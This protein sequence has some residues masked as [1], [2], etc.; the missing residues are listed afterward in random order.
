MLWSLMI[1]QDNGTIV[2]SGVVSSQVQQV[3]VS[4]AIEKWNLSITEV[5][6][7]YWKFAL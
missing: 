4:I 5:V 2:V 6:E 1:V 7:F 3:F